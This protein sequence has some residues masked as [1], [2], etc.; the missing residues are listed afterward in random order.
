MIEM[1]KIELEGISLVKTPLKH[2][3]LSACFYTMY[4]QSN[5]KDYL[6]PK[7]FFFKL[8]STEWIS[9]QFILHKI[10]TYF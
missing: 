2:Q 9:F 7:D 10:L 1:L 6:Y 8:W 5:T 3:N 4:L